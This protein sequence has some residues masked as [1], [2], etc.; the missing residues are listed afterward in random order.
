MSARLLLFI[1]LI[2]SRQLSAQVCDSWRA[3]IGDT[4]IDLAPPRGFIEVCSLDPQLC[5]VL[6][7]GYPPSVKTLGYFAAGRDWELFRRDSSLGFKHYL[8]AQLALNKTAEQLPGFKAYLRAQQGNIPDHSDLPRML[9][10][11]GRVPLG[12]LAETPT[13]ISSGVIMAARPVTSPSAESIVLVASNS[14]VAVTNRLLSLYVYHDY[15]TQTDIDTVKVVTQRWLQCIAD[16][17]PK[18]DLRASGYIVPSLD[19]S[20]AAFIYVLGSPAA[21]ETSST[22]LQIV[23]DEPSFRPTPHAWSCSQGGIS[24][25]AWRSP[26]ELEVVCTTTAGPSPS[27][28]GPQAT[29]SVDVEGVTVN[30][31]QYRITA[32]GRPDRGRLDSIIVHGDTVVLAGELVA[33]GEH[34]HITA[35]RDEVNVV[36]GDTSYVAIAQLDTTGTL[37]NGVPFIG[38]ST[39]QLTPARDLDIT[40]LRGVPTRRI[41]R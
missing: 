31:K 19:K 3:H 38:Y 20:K 5:S 1:G 39:F 12:I 16:A 6:T 27:Q 40:Q 11:Q 29:A 14:A 21:F 41:I 37:A 32:W 30:M 24:W 18:P 10:A 13:S 4:T 36:M 26:S 8:I 28:R 33:S 15:R 35:R 25:V 7:A 17:A 34:V 23:A 9:V 22:F 2:S